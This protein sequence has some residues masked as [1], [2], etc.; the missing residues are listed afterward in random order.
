MNR[1]H[2]RY[3]AA[4]KLVR[5]VMLCAA[6]LGANAMLRAHALDVPIGEAALLVHDGRPHSWGQLWRTWGLDP[7]VIMGV[8]LTGALYL[9]GITR[10]WRATHAGGGILRWQAGCFLAGWLS[11]VVALIS[12]LHPWGEV[13][14]SA[15]MVQHELL[16]V[17]A[18]PLLILGRPMLAAM[19]A[20]PTRW[21]KS[22]VSTTAIRPLE[23]LWT[24]ASAPLAAWL[25]HA[26]ALWA[27]HV[28]SLFQLALRSPFAH[29]LQ[30]LSFFL[31]GLV[32]WW[33]VVHGRGR[34]RAYGTGILYMFTTALHTGVLGALLAVSGKQW[35]PVYS[36]TCW[37]WGLTPLEDQQLG[38]LIMWIPASTAYVIAAL[39]F[40]VQWLRES[41]RRV[42][43]W[44]PEPVEG[45]T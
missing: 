42:M 36:L 24:F 30:H 38:G 33:A 29:A 1:G 26:I 32:F 31:S 45:I 39:F 23:G 37:Q 17:V 25:I 21:R 5:V 15:H 2:R 10:L 13:L 22:V 34:T 9:V 8:G 43:H 3:R 6:L 44:N 28:P 41:D 14:F 19:W 12:P 4:P 7:G 27:W 16:T 18:A 40:F 35:Y 11:L 20:L